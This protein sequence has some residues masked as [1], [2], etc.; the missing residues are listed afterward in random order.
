MNTTD[1]SP[2]SSP[3]ESGPWGRANPSGGL[4]RARPPRGFR[5]VTAGVQNVRFGGTVPVSSG[6]TPAQRAGLAFETKVHDVL[7]AIYGVDYRPHPAILYEDRGRLRRAIPD[8]VLRLGNTAMVVEVKLTHT[9]RAWWQLRR[10]YIPLLRHL[11]KPG[12][13]V[14]GVEICRSFDP[15]L[16]WPEPFEILTSLHKL[17]GNLGVIQ[18]RL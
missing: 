3:K 11:T 17:K 6:H 1:I 18:W 5:P 16:K 2:L 15:D 9:D 8:G 10:L 14:V 13:L 4:V 7:A 12:V